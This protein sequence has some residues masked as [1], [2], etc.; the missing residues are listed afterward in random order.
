M[1]CVVAVG[2][3][4]ALTLPSAEIARADPVQYLVNLGASASEA[5]GTTAGIAVLDRVTGVYSDNGHNAHMS[6]G[7]ASLVKLF[8][9]DSVL[10]RARLGQISLSLTDR[11]SLSRML[12]SSDDTVASNLWVRFGSSGIVRD[13]VSRYHL[14]ETT[15]PANPRYWGLTQV[16]AHDMVTFYKGML[17][18]SAGLASADR[19]IVVAALRQSTSR[20]TDGYYQWFGLHDG[21]PHESVLGIKQ[22]WMCCFSDGYIWRH[23]TGLV[24]PDA[25]YIVVVLTRDPGSAGSAHTVA[26]TT[27]AVQRMF[28]AGLIPR[29]QGAIGDHWYAMGGPSSRLGLPTTSETAASG[30]GAYSRFQRGVIYCSAT[31]G[32]RFAAGAILNSWAAAG[33][34][35]SPLGYPTTDETAVPGG[36]YNR[37]QGGVI[38]W[39]AGTGAHAVTGALLTAWAA[40]GY[41]RGSLGYP[42]SDAHT[43]SSGTRVDFQHGTL[44]LTP[45]GQV[46]RVDTPPTTPSAALRIAGTTAVTTSSS[47]TTAPS[48]P[49]TTTAAPA[50]TSATRTTTAPAPTATPTTTQGQ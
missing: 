9:A 4:V 29:V 47:A 36:A 14:T 6:F 44:T 12:R 37:F 38:Y 48:T 22:G 13:V 32:A 24:G 28:P 30:G 18:G 40:D 2:A 33:Y 8:I 20:G 27:V 45:T 10:R 49:P 42:T 1:R 43:F 31:T 46:V 11:N 15:P 7:S 25:R 50:T 23:S 19:D 26:S 21:L 5:R 35:H 34:E 39:S 16:T 41:E 17:T 3:A